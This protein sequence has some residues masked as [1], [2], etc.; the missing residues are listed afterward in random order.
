M[1][2]SVSR[3]PR[4]IRDRVSER[5]NATRH[6][7]THRDNVVKK[8]VQP[9]SSGHKS[10]DPKSSSHS[11]P[12]PKSSSHP[13]P[14]PSTSSHSVSSYP[15]F[16]DEEG[17]EY[18]HGPIGPQAPVR[19]IQGTPIHVAP[20]A[21]TRGRDMPRSRAYANPSCEVKERDV[22][23][24]MTVEDR[25]ANHKNIV[26]GRPA[27]PSASILPEEVL[28]MAHTNS[29]IALADGWWMPTEDQTL[30]AILRVPDGKCGPIRMVSKNFH[31][32][33][34]VSL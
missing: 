3:D 15:F 27:D 26:P 12:D 2:R 11:L 32:Q 28:A 9:K 19:K 21:F 24:E 7:K 31:E 14:R 13:V 30:D 22:V 1:A 25:A 6:S 10:P 5:D 8:R 20:Q 23:V 29:S 17:R 18:H 34:N 33:K 4:S 16:S